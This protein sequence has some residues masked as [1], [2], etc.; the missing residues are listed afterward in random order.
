MNAE[1]LK[2]AINLL[3][4][5]DYVFSLTYDNAGR[6]FFNSERPFT[7]DMIQGEFIAIEEVS[8][9]G[10][11]TVGLKPIEVVQTIV[12]VKDP[13]D[14]DRIDMHYYKS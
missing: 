7:M 5:V 14:R 3:G 2:A 4:G 9:E 6:V 12:G 13:Q 11:I 10:I 1:Q 8:M